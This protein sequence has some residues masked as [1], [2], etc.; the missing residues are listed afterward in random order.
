MVCNINKFFCNFYLIELPN[1]IKD[2]TSKENTFIIRK[3]VLEL[4]RF[5]CPIRT[6]SNFINTEKLQIY[7]YHKFL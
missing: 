6:V 7:L 2:S 1:M 3:I 5:F 4:G